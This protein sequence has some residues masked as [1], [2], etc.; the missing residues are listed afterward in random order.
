V[1]RAL[2]ATY[3]GLLGGA[4]RVLLECAAGLEGDHVLACPA[5]P[6]A[7]VAEQTGLTVLRLPARS[8]VLRDAART[9]ARAIAA[10]AAHARELRRL[11]RDL[12]PELVIAWGMRSALATLGVARN[13]P[14]AADHHDFLPG[15][16][17]AALVRLA[18]RRFDVVTVP[19]RA[20][21]ADLGGEA[22]HV[23]VIHPGVD[24]ERL[25]AVAVPGDLSTVVTV[26]AMTGWKRP[27]LALEI[28]ARARRTRPELHLRLV[29]PEI[30]REPRLREQLRARTAQPDLAGAVTFVGAVDEI[31]T[32]LARA[33]CLLHCADREPFGIVLAEA[34]AAGRPV[35]APDAAGPREIVEPSCGA[36]FAP[37]DAE[38]GA[39]ALL[40]IVS[41]ANGAAEMGRAGR[42][43]A[44]AH[45]DRRRM[46]AQFREVLE[47]VGE[48]ARPGRT[49]ASD[50]QLTIVTVSHN[51]AGE[52]PGMLASVA[53]YL[54]GAEVLVVDSASSDESRV[55][56]AAAGARVV[57]LADNVGFGRASNVGVAEATRDVIALLN[58]DVRLVD[59][60]LRC[61]AGEALRAERLLAPLV[62]NPDGTRQQTVHPV[63]AAA[64]DLV[65]A[66]VP[67]TAV[68]VPWLAPWRS[69]TPRRVGWAV[70]AA[71]LARADTLRRLG[72]FD[73]S[74]FM[75][76]EDL[77]LGLR[78]VA[79]GVETWFWPQARVLH[80]GAHSAS[81]AFRG[82]PFA[83]LARAR[84]EV[85]A[86][87][88]GP[89]RA[90]RDDRAQALTFASRA[91]LKAAIGRPRQ[92]E[93]AQLAAVR[94]LSRDP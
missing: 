62:L 42:R 67:P 24:V 88:L 55:V 50:E 48:K 27:D 25:A 3:S 5:G 37:G 90:Q 65:R 2:F 22:E 38:A 72:P 29:G 51:S 15:P 39:R 91:A 31:E 79:S 78:A 92:R 56:S 40:G 76:G 57:A 46:Q 59:N 19:S 61:L 54:P 44:A 69:R 23:R 94:A 16:A 9:R 82:E 73:E 75:Y 13:V 1:T 60:S 86:R 18:L 71:L 26:G 8:L 83:R 30:T 28:L 43:R 47:G 10:L 17:I 35:V 41:D 14:L 21:A 70:G 80:A 85:V 53:R 64:A 63:P 84:H 32:E 4:E 77:E 89:R 68:P 11:V 7:D 34:L 45:F 20:V 66:A 36:R 12:E 6:L 81:V 58:P 93:H 49:P 74:I 33:G 52:L 87:H